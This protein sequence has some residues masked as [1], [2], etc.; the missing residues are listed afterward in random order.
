LIN[1]VPKDDSV[2]FHGAIFSWGPI[3]ISFS[4]F[5]HIAKHKNVEYYTIRYRIILDERLS[6]FIGLRFQIDNMTTFNAIKNIII[7]CVGTLYRSC[8][9]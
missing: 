5:P 7:I 6:I 4:V 1:T 8:K 2:I 9:G 3:E